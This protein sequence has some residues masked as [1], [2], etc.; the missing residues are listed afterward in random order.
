MLIAKYQSLQKYTLE[1]TER[2]RKIAKERLDVHQAK[3]DL[4]SQQKKLY[5]SRCSLCKIGENADQLKS[6][7]QRDPNDFDDIN[8][9]KLNIENFAI[10]S[11]NFG[12]SY[13]HDAHVLP[14]LDLEKVPNIDIND[15][16]LD[17]ADILM[18]K[19]DAFKSNLNNLNFK[20]FN[21]NM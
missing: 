4:Q 18:L 11:D 12:T 16:Y 15:D 6:I 19:F 9:Q 1:L 2:E 8:T 10:D 21:T 14:S 3:L 5:E 17:E 20:N 7:I 13:D